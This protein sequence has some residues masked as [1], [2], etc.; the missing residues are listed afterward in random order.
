MR[1]S[2]AA[3]LLLGS[4][5]IADPTPQYQHLPLLR[6]QAVLQDKWTAERKASIPKLLQKHN[7]DAWLV[8]FSL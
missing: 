3:A 4:L 7:V 6:D 2:S 8:H 5:A 1:L